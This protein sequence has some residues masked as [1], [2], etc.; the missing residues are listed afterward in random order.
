MDFFSISLAFIILVHCLHGYLDIRQLGALKKPQP[1]ASLAGGSSAAHSTPASAHS[2]GRGLPVTMHFVCCAGLF[3]NELFESSKAYSIDKW[4]F[5]FW[6]GQYSLVEQVL[7]LWFMPWLWYMLP[8]ILPQ[9]LV[10]N[11][12]SRTVCFMLLLSLVGLVTSLPWSYYSTCGSAWAV[13]AAGRGVGH[14]IRT[15]SSSSSNIIR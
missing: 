7:N 14:I 15:C 2:A 12:I 11:E 1:P 3:T 8:S 13:P 10:A 6:H 5:N 9:Q 4:H